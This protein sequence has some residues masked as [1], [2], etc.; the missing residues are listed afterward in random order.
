MGAQM[1]IAAKSIVILGAGIGGL[2]AAIAL[3]QR[4]AQVQIFE[5]SDAIR[6]VGAGIQISP[7]GYAVIKAL[8]LG[9]V[10]EQRATR[11]DAIRLCDART[12]QPVLQFDLKTL[13]PKQGY[14]FIHR[15]DLIDILA[16]AARD[17]GVQISLLSRLLSTEVID[18]QPKLHFEH[19]PALDADLVIGADG[20][21]SKIR[22]FLNPQTK[23]F[24]TNQVAWRAIIPNDPSDHNIAEVHMGPGRHLVSYPLRGG[25]LRNIVAVEERA[26]WSEES[27][28]LREDPIDMQMAFSKF[29]PR[30]RHWLSLVEDVWLWGLFRHPV[31]PVWQ[32]HWQ[33]GAMVLLG[34]AAPPT[35]PFLAQGGS[36]A[37]EDAWVLAAELHHKDR[38][39]ALRDYENMRAPRCTRIVQAAN[40]NARLYHLSGLSKVIG[41][42]G[43]QAI[44]AIAP[45][46]PLRRLDW[47]YD[48]DVTGQS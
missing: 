8:G 29:S 26:R 23:A 43:L 40:I 17:L 1:S 14:Y 7:N 27:W 15:A 11:A 44:G 18:A 34:D 21:H 36:M 13:L 48:H 46:F 5:Q 3:T 37:L 45:Q 10:F 22:G 4:G 42:I 24:F 30:V 28:S 33:N 39:V 32:Q 9:E 47:L 25:S 20:M 19:G 16:N 41:H 2:A 31:A 38:A 35:L 6:D 12:A